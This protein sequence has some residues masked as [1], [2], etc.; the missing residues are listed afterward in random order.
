MISKLI[1]KEDPGISVVI[2]AYNR[3]DYLE[4]ALASVLSQS[5]P[6]KEII[7]VDDCSPIE[8][9]PVVE[10]FRN[11]MIRYI[12]SESN[13]GANASRNIGVQSAS[14]EYVAF[15][16]DDDI[17]KENKLERQFKVLNDTTDCNA[18]LCGF[19]FLES[20][21]VKVRTGEKEV[22]KEVLKKG[23]PYCG[24]SG[25][26]AK[27]STLA[28]HRFDESLVCGQDW[29]IYVRLFQSGTIAYVDQALFYYRFGTHEGISS[30][31][32]KMTVDSYSPRLASIVKH[33]H[34]LG[35]KYYRY[36]TSRQILIEIS[37]KNRKYSWLM[38]SL[39]EGGLVA[40]LS[41]FLD[42]VK[43]RVSIVVQWSGY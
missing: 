42:M 9:K 34:W 28:E 4:A 40:T 21:R 23:N 35:E 18:V 41:A 16:D 31:A 8:L 17:W 14:G 2:S 29:D 15:L 5:L 3:P 6:A 43:K 1:E 27:R 24:M 11:V 32:R 19:E 38:Y 7:V 22:V 20:G 39:R 33:R 30:K 13:M 36:R 37:K 12:R 10:S 25:F 26:M